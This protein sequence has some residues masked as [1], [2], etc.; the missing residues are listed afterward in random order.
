MS[1]DDELQPAMS[2]YKQSLK[3]QHR[4]H[5]VTLYMFLKAVSSQSSFQLFPFSNFIILHLFILPSGDRRV[6]ELKLTTDWLK[7]K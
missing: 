2:Q 7:R 5:T 4:L 1:T 6:G 3:Q